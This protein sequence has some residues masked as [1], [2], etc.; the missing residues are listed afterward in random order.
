MLSTF[1]DTARFGESRGTVTAYSRKRTLH[2][3]AAVLAGVLIVSSAFAGDLQAL[4][5]AAK[6]FVSAA[7]EQEATLI[8]Y[9]TVNELAGDTMAYAAAKKRYLS[10]FRSA[11]P[12]VIAV[13]IEAVFYIDFDGWSEVLC[14]V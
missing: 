12:I 7:K 2:F 13:E 11:M 1:A 6:A 9:P 3:L 14:T 5:V 4:C 10:E 8:T